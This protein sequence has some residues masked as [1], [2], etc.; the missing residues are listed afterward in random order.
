MVVPAGWV[1]IKWRRWRGRTGSGDH[2]ASPRLGALQI[3]FKDWGFRVRGSLDPL[4]GR[5]MGAGGLPVHQ[6]PVGSKPGE[7]C[8]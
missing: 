1:G 3:C 4:A 7:F 5:S 6:T 2:R 8:S